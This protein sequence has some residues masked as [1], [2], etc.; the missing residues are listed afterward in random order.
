[1]KEKKTS[2]KQW[3]EE[4]RPREKLLLK[5]KAVL[6]E[7]ELIGIL[8]GSGT[9]TLTAVDLA[10]QILHSVNNNLN[11]LAKL[12]INA[13]KK[14]NGIGE[15]KAIS[16]VS[17]LE[18]GRRRKETE[19]PKV[20]KIT[21]SKSVYEIMHPYLQDLSHEEFW[22]ILLNR[23]NQLIAKP[24]PI[25][26][27]GVS[28]TIVDPKIIFNKA[29]EVIASNIILVHNHPSGNL[30]PS[31]ADINITKKIKEAG[32]LLE[33]PVL[34]HLIYTDSSYLSMADEGYF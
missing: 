29:L 2:I 23:A 16:I 9:R 3:A 1:L 11:I 32:Q 22:I 18:L 28:G 21:S 19:Y 4:D 27:G 12:S 6:S 13:L 5:G 33:I 31:Q 14:F 20:V 34:D 7:A 15:A 26:Q 30:K 10:K 8:I 17:A 25:S 24:L